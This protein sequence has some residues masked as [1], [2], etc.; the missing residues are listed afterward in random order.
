M[1]Y[2]IRLHVVV[3]NYLSTK[4]NVPFK[5]VLLYLRYELGERVAVSQQ[6]VRKAALKNSSPV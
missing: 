1:H 4:T 6:Y 2:P 5:P 3:L